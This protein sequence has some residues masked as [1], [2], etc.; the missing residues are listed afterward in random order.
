MRVFH[1]KLVR[2][3]LTT[4]EITNDEKKIQSHNTFLHGVE[5]KISSHIVRY[6]NGHFGVSSDVLYSN[7]R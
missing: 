7:V 6:E 2:F 4:Q 5:P 3:S 1:A